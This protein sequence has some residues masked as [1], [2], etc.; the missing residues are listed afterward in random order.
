MLGQIRDA[1][2]GNFALGGKRFQKDIE[3]ALGRRATAV[4]RDGRGQDREVGEGQ[5]GLL[6]AEHEE[7]VVCPRYPYRKNPNKQVRT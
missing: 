5:L 3:S 2:N 7:N 6:W 1:T 4:R